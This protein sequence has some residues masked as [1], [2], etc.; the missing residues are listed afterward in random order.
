MPM[1]HADMS[2]HHTDLTEVM[3][4]A[5][6]GAHNPDAHAAAMEFARQVEGLTDHSDMEEGDH[7]PLCTLSHGAPLSEIELA[8][9][10]LVFT[11]RTDFARYEPSFIHS[12]RGP[13][14]GARGPPE[15]I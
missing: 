5:S 7:C 12:A 9:S 6:D 4:F 11:Q 3:C 1:A 14:V 13:P 10:N 8:Q 2:H 15:H